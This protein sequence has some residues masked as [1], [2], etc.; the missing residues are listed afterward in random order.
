VSV[1]ASGRSIF[2]SDVPETAFLTLTFECGATAN[3]QVSWL[4]PRKV[5]QMVIVGSKRMVQYDDAAS[6]ASVRVYDRGLDMLPAPA[7]FGEHQLTYRS[8]DMVAPFIDAAEPLGLEL[9]DFALAINTGARPRSHARLGLEIVRVLD[10]AKLSL[11][12]RGRPV[13]IQ[14]SGNELADTRTSRFARPRRVE[15]V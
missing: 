14:D 6:D 9:E 10:A 11:E 15:A 8:G 1:T 12:N 3:I 5:R 7:N 4:A 2:Q 13:A